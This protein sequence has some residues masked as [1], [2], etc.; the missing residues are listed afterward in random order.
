MTR[1][2][3]AC[4]LSTRSERRSDVSDPNTDSK[5]WSPVAPERV[6]GR[7]TLRRRCDSGTS[8]LDFPVLCR[9]VRPREE[10]RQRDELVPVG[11]TEQDRP[12]LAGCPDERIRLLDLSPD[13]RRRLEH[14]AHMRV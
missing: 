11:G 14:H 8:P 7:R 10:P 9:S 1:Y 6:H 12:A 4:R 13:R 3:R 2:P 5:M